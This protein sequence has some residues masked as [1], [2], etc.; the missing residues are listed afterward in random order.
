M[1]ICTGV[2]A[3]SAINGGA[4]PEEEEDVSLKK[5]TKGKGEIMVRRALL[6]LID[7][8]IV[9][10]S[11]Y[12]GLLLRADGAPEIDTWW[13]HNLDLLY[14]NLPW[15]AALYMLSFLVGGLYSILWKYASERDLI[16]LA[17]MVAV[18]T[19]AVYFVNRLLIHGVLF[20]SANCIAA[21][22]VLLFVGGTRMAWRM[23]L[24]HPIGSALRGVPSNDPNRPMLIVGA[25]EAGAWAI[26][27]CKSNKTYG[28][29]VVVADDA[30]EKLNQTIHGVPVKGTLEDIPELCARY[31]IYGIINRQR[32]AL[33]LMITNAVVDIA[34]GVV[35][36]I[37]PKEVA[38]ILLIL[39]GILALVFGIAQLVILISASRVVNSGPGIFVL[40]VLC[41]IGGIILLTKPSDSRDVLVLLSGI[42]VLVYGVSEFVAT[43]KMNR[44]MKAF[45]SESR[46]GDSAKEEMSGAKDVDY[47]KVK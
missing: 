11:F 35:L 24:D 42:V 46:E 29:P 9:C 15:I 25:G 8:F 13:P 4:P 19:V 30:P 33:S 43:W 14:K 16:R 41:M 39:I 45:E 20:N 40:P 36:F 17:V 32:G 18:P 3:Q 37:F 7:L 10:F 38:D 12:L 44:A 23:F 1:C 26:N 21:V 2:P 6:F 22:F 47:E 5:E 27:V 31:N 34:I 28:R